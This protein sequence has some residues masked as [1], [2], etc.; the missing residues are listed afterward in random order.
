MIRFKQLR[1][2]H[3]F[4]YGADNVLNLDQAPLVQLVGQNGNGKTSIALILEE[5]LFNKN[6][7]GT[8]KASILNRYSKEK[9]YTISLDFSVGED[10]Y[11]VDTRR[12]STQTVTL[13]KNGIDIS[14]H[15]STG[16][17]KQIE[18]IL[19]W[20]HK[21]FT[22]IVNQSSASSL[23]FLTA[24][25]SN[26]KKFLI[27]LLDLSEYVKAG[28][29]FKD[30][31]KELEGN[32]AVI[33]GKISVLDTVISNYKEKDLVRK[34]IPEKLV[35]DTDSLRK[36][37]AT[38]DHSLS[39]IVE[40]NKQITQNNQYKK[41]L[42]SIIVRPLPERPED[43]RGELLNTIAGIRAE[44]N[45]ANKVITKFSA[46]KGC[47]PTC[48]NPIDENKIQQL[49]SENTA[50]KTSGTEAIAKIEHTIKQQEKALADW[51]ALKKNNEQYESYHSL[52]NPT[53]QS[54]LLDRDELSVRKQVL[55]EQIKDLDAQVKANIAEIS[56]AEAWNAR[57]AAIEEQIVSSRKQ[58]EGLVGEEA[59][60]KNQKSLVDVLVKTFST[61]GLVAYKIECLV[62]DLEALTNQYL[63]EF[64]DGQFQITFQLNGSDK[65]NVVITDNGTDVEI[66][67]LSN[68]ERARVNISALLAIRKLL[69][70]LSNNQA[71]LLFLDEVTE[72]LDAFGKEKL[73]EILLEETHLNTILVSHS[74]THPLLE[75]VQVIKEN[76]I[77]RIE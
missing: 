24:T 71:N 54:D 32:L 30:K 40:R 76:K 31:A 23:E 52:Y 48:D 65:L 45:G 60:L 50:L 17:Y 33:K 70:G 62:K 3:A 6:S 14:S 12:G 27:E 69:Q 43:T 68:G 64:S 15:T 36:E 47:C 41:M 72:N 59:V 21:K 35:V 67:E 61:S 8:K 19:G 4:S 38:I 9:A 77:S 63:A 75:K 34:P 49:V 73:I 26:R 57:V 51:E 10:E 13:T 46:L 37:V 39:T 58:R 55:E 18:D 53:L 22:Q 25:D 29:H 44:I 16:T 1:W 11:T 7:K 56:A 20:D 28:E 66:V 2:S 74:F 42:D 5:V